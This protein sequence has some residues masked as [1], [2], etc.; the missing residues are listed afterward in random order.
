PGLVASERIFEFLDAPVE[1]RD[2]A[3]ARPFP[4]VQEAIVFDD[5]SF[6]YHPRE[7]VL[8]GVSFRAEAGSVTALVGPSGAGKTTLVDLLGRFYDPTAGR[9]LVDG[10]EIGAFSIASIRERLGI[11]SQDTVLFHDTVRANIAYGME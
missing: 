10:V 6:A 11:V 7:L 5:V 3:D 9:I 2:R 1:I 8:N 4:G